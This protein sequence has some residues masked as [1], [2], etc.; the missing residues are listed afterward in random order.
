[1]N[2]QTL[3]FGEVQI[4]EYQVI[5]FQ[6]GI[7]GFNEF[8]QFV[9]LDIEDNPIYKVLQSLDEEGLAFIVTN[10]FLIYK[11]YEFDLDDA[12]AEQ[13]EIKTKEDVSI[14]SIVT[15][16]EPFD[17]STINLKAPIILNLNKGLGKQVVLNLENYHTKHSIKGGELSHARTD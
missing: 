10:P 7:P 16:E 1:M 9:L 14:F 6:S 15:V 17:Q 11:G 3:Y 12:V 5:K 2:I 13:L 8:K 4:D